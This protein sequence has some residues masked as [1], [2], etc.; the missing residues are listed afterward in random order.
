VHISDALRVRMP[1][2]RLVPVSS[3]DTEVRIHFSVHLVEDA[4]RA[5][6]R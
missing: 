1:I 3:V 2:D 5:C 6:K 4:E